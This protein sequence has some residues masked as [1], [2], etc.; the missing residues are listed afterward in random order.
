[1]ARTS[2]R[3][4][5]RVGIEPEARL[6][7]L[8]NFGNLERESLTSEQRAAVRQEARAFAILQEIDPAIRGRMRYWPA[9]AEATRDALTDDEIWRAQQWLKRG[10]DL[11]GRSEKWNF[12]PRV[13]Y[14]LDA[15]R[16]MLW[17]RTRATSRLELFKALAYE[18]FRDARLRF[19]LCP[20]CRRAF[21]PIRRQVYCSGRCSQAVRTR[22]WR[23]ANPEKNREIRRAQYRKSMTAKLKLSTA[24]AVRIAKRR[25]SK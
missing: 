12:T 20:H 25:P 3:V 19:R 22:K 15:Y 10:L 1:M 11:L 6:R 21:V 23:Q 2:N 17:T 9:P 7:W 5:D 8:L 13:K 18:A 14:E 16:G 4:W 24:A